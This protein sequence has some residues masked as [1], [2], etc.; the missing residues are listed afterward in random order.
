M[1]FIFAKYE[2]RVETAQT[3]LCVGLDPVLEKIP[4]PFRSAQLP[5]FA[6]NRYIIDATAPY[7]AAYKPNSAF[8]EAHGAHGFEQLAM[9]A[10]YLRENYPD[11]VTI[12][13][14]KRGDNANTNQAYVTAIFDTLGFDAVTLHPYLGKEALAPFLAR[15]DKACILLCRTS[16]SGAGEF[17]DLQ[18]EGKSLWE[19]VADRVANAWDRDGNCM[20]V[21]GATYPEEMR[22]IRALAPR[23]TLLVPGIGAQ[24]GDLQAVMA[25]GL[26]REGRG[27]M[28]SSSREILYSP[29]PAA[30]AR[31]LRDAI[32][33][34]RKDVH[35][36][37]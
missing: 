37:H 7:A 2:S 21:V 5:L 30:A 29:D 8:Y 25:A 15:T 19:I 35:A 6:F 14:A 12:C 16:N 23:T 18:H 13:D 34:A 22:R 4:E 24:G 27:L 28:I 36:A 3:L 1:N 10:E 20:L 31:G 11:I 9:T 17:Q 33:A 26:N 32:E